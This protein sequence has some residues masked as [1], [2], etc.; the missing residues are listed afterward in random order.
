MSVTKS[1]DNNINSIIN[2]NSLTEEQFDVLL[3]Q[4]VNS[5]IFQISSLQFNLST[6]RSRDFELYEQ[7]EASIEKIKQE[8]NDMNFFEESNENSFL[9]EEEYNKNSQDDNDNIDFNLDLINNKILESDSTKNSNNLQVG[10]IDT[11]TNLKE[12]STII[13][14]KN[15][16]SL[17]TNI[18]KISNNNSFNTNYSTHNSININSNTTSNNQL[19]LD[20]DK[21]NT[22]LDDM[23][24]SMDSYIHKVSTTEFLKSELNSNNVS[25]QDI[26]IGNKK[27]LI[28][29]FRENKS[30]ESSHNKLNHSFN[31]SLNNSLSN[32]RKSAF[33]SS[34]LLSKS[35]DKNFIENSKVDNS[36]TQEN[37]DLNLK[38][39]SHSHKDDEKLN[40]ND[41]VS[42]IILS[43]SKQNKSQNSS[44]LLNNKEEQK[45]LREDLN[46]SNI[47]NSQNLSKP[48]LPLNSQSFIIESNLKNNGISNSLINFDKATSNNSILSNILNKS[49]SSNKSFLNDDFNSNVLN[50]SQ[51]SNKSFVNNILEDNHQSVMNK[52]QSSNKSFIN[53]NIEDIN[54]SILNK[55]QS[56]NKSIINDNFEDLNKNILNKSQLSNK[57]MIN[58]N[59]EDFNKN[60]LNKSQSSNKSIINSNI[61]DIGKNILNK[62]HTSNKSILNNILDISSINGVKQDSF[63]KE[64]AATLF[65]AQKESLNNLDM[66]YNGDNMQEPIQVNRNEVSF[67]RRS[68]Y[69]YISTMNKENNTSMTDNS[70]YNY[71]FNIK[72]DKNNNQVDI[73]DKLDINYLNV[74]S[75][76]QKDLPNQNNISIINKSFNSQTSKNENNLSQI[77]SHLNNSFVNNVKQNNNN[78]ASIYSAKEFSNS[79]NGKTK[80]EL[81]ESNMDN[82]LIQSKNSPVKTSQLNNSMHRNSIQGTDNLSSS[83]IKYIEGIKS[84]YND[85]PSEKVNK[86][87]LKELTEECQH[88]KNL[89]EVQLKLNKELETKLGKYNIK[90]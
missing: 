54:K 13:N 69:E 83:V 2:N 52:S 76:V 50:K 35:T 40:N 85:L 46:T 15:N 90:E 72:N 86:M 63:K 77:N 45:I 7:P 67:D 34:N 47:S 24:K 28:E 55:S 68:I 70:I 62:S 14:N 38:T 64:S 59:F 33:D 48:P 81:N 56:S 43:T 30:V 79:V 57:S 4:T 80:N 1:D 87:V 11:A 8:L 39:I 60:I 44:Y 49:Q 23:E 32:K 25:F 22:S 74:D 36:I 53:G 78:S 88:L 58:D 65:D 17:E 37:S 61:E 66:I 89:N 51:S 19:N 9:E 10:V 71:I 5:D 82:S 21:R 6:D 31:L 73:N 12:N 42:S 29:I 16:I 26:K 3:N 27:S 41:S 18:T 20:V 84:K 75:N